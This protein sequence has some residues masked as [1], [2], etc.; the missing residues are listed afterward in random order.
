MIRGA[1]RVDEA[2]ADRFTQFIEQADESDCMRRILYYTVTREEAGLRV[3]Q[4]LKRRGYSRQILTEL[5]KFAGSVSV[6]G[7][8]YYMHR[9]EKA[10]RRIV[11]GR[12]K[13]KKAL[14]D[15]VMELP[16]IGYAM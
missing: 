7:E 10:G 4:Y 13:K 1:G 8:E 9:R 14:P 5:K 6:D 2:L 12:K 15:A 11:V 3:D 16:F